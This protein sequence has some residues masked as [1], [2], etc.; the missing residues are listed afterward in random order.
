MATLNKKEFA[1]LIGYSPRQLG[2]WL[3]RGLPCERSGKKG[4]E[5]EIDSVA[6]IR[7]M[8]ENV[9]VGRKA[10][11]DRDRLAR[12]QAD[13]AEF[14]NRVRRGEFISVELFGE[15]IIALSGEVI[16]QMSG[17][18][19]RVAGKIAGVQDPAIVR[20]RLM[21]ECNGVRSAFAAHLRGVAGISDRVRIEI[22]S[23]GDADR[24]AAED[25]AGSVG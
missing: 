15:T 14:E 18:P 24:P 23:G 22:E 6:A 17:L 16:G 21:D 19:G 13:R 2:E 20:T 4:Q 10:S 8:M 11:E 9:S 12:A 7:W 25:I 5:V 1:D 3:D